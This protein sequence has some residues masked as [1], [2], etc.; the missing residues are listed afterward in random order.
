MATLEHDRF[1]PGGVY[2]DGGFVYYAEWTNSGSLRDEMRGRML[3]MPAEGGSVGE[4]A[5]QPG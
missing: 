1:Q 5:R 4:V 3:R 2:V